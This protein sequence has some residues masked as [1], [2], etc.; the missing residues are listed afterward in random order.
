MPRGT[1]DTGCFTILYVPGPVAYEGGCRG[2]RGLH[3][4]FEPSSPQNSAGNRILRASNDNLAPVV[5]EAREVRA[6]GAQES[7]GGEGRV[8]AVRERERG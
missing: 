3:G 6:N 2:T 5:S 4:G 1:R 7:G 8:A